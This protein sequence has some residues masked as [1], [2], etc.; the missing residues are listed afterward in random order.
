RLIASGDQPPELQRLGQSI[1][2]NDDALLS[3]AASA[4]IQVHVLEEDLQQQALNELLAHS[5]PVGY[6]VHVENDK[7]VY[8]VPEGYPK[9]EVSEIPGEVIVFHGQKLNPHDIAVVESIH[10][11]WQQAQG[12]N[13]TSGLTTKI[14]KRKVESYQYVIRSRQMAVL[15]ELVARQNAAVNE[16]Q[17]T[18]AGEDNPEIPSLEMR[19][20]LAIRSL[21]YYESL[22][23]ALAI[24]A[25]DQADEVE[26]TLKPEHIK[27][28]SSFIT[29]TWLQMQLAKH[30]SFKP[31]LRNLLNKQHFVQNMLD[32]TL[33][34][35][36]KLM[37]DFIYND[38][39]FAD[40]IRRDLAR[41]LIEVDNK[42]EELQLKEAKLVQF[43]NQLQ[44]ATERADA[45]DKEK[46][47][48]QYRYQDAKFAY[49]TL[50]R[51]M[52]ELE[53]Q[54]QKL[55]QEVKQI[56]KLEQQL[57]DA[58]LEARKTYNSELA[59]MLGIDDWDDTQPPEG[60]ARRLLEKINDM[61][62]K[63]I[64]TYTA[65][66]TS[67]EEAL[68]AKPAAFEGI[69]GTTPINE[70][71]LSYSANG[72]VPNIDK[73]LDATGRSSK[74]AAKAKPAAIEGR[75]GITPV[76]ENDLIYNV[77]G[78]MLI[79]DETLLEGANPEQILA[80][81][82][83]GCGLVP[84][85]KAD[86]KARVRAI[87]EHI[88]HVNHPSYLRQQDEQA[89]QQTVQQQS[90][91]RTEAEKAAATKARLALIASHLNMPDFDDNT[92]IDT[93]HKLL[94]EKIKS[95]NALT[96]K[97]TKLSDDQQSEIKTLREENT[98]QEEDIARLRPAEQ[99][100]AIK[101]KLKKPADLEAELESL[102]TP[103]HIVKPEVL[104]KLGAVEKALKM[105]DF[106]AEDD[107]Y[108]RRNAISE[109]LQT[110]ITK[111][112][113]RAEEDAL[114]VLK[115][116]EEIF[117][118]KVNEG[119]DNR[120]RLHRIRA[121]LDGDDVT[122]KKLDDIENALSK[123]KF[124]SNYE[125]TGTKPGKLHELLTFFVEDAD[126]R[127]LAQQTSMLKTAEDELGIATSKNLAAIERGKDSVAKLAEK[128]QVD[129]I[130]DAS[131]EE[132]KGSLINRIQTLKPLVGSLSVD[133]EG[134]KRY[135]NNHIAR[136]L[137][138]E[139]YR[140]D[141][142]IDDQVNRILEKL[143]ELE[144][145]A[146]T[147][148]Q[149]DTHE[150]IE[151]IDA[152]L[153]RQI[154]R[155][156]PKPRYTLDREVTRARR[157]VA[158]AESELKATYRKLENVR[159]KRQISAGPA[160][161]NPIT[162]EDKTTPDQVMK[163]L[164]ANL[165]LTPVDKQTTEERVNDIRDLLHGEDSEKQYEIAQQLK[166]TTS[167]LKISVDGDPDRL[168]EEDYFN[169]IVTHADTY[170][171]DEVDYPA[172]ELPETR[173]K[174]AQVT[175]FLH[176][177]A[178]RVMEMTHAQDEEKQAQEELNTINQAIDHSKDSDP[179]AKTKLEDER[180][181]Q[182]L[183][184]KQKRAVISEA[185]EDLEAHVATL[186]DLEDNVGLKPDPTAHYTDR[187]DALRNKQLELGGDDG[188]GG[189]I[190]QLTGEQDTLNRE[191]EVRKSEIDKLKKVLHAAEEAAENEGG[192]FQY[193]PGQARIL[194]DLHAYMQ[195]H[196]LKKQALEAVIGLSESAELN[197]KS[198]PNLQTFDLDD[199]FAPIRLQ[200]LAGDNLPFN[201]ASR[202]V[203]VFKDLKATFTFELAEDQSL[204][205]LEE[206]QMLAS[207]ARIYM[208][209]GAQQFDDEIHGIGE[210][211]IHFIEHEPEGLKSFSEYF[212]THSASGHRIITLLREGLI[213]K[214]ELEHYM[215]A[216]RG[217]DGYQLVDE[218]EHFI[219][220]KHGVRVPEF[221]KV[222]QMLS[223]KGAEEFMQSAFTPVTVTTNGPAGMKESFAGMKEYAASVIANYVLDDI[224]F[225]NGR[226]TAAFLTNVQDT[227]TP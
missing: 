178:L 112:R 193:T 44:Q 218:F 209:T 65:P 158:D 2:V 226:R 211:A 166:A 155:L 84:V 200:A 53:S 28:A 33:A 173:R 15:E 88:E 100:Y 105:D 57:H 109:A 19:D 20:R 215:K 175:K 123:E 71:D 136:V 26:F 204:N 203:A 31:V 189:K 72:P 184:L 55:D 115:T 186:R 42:L 29:H 163:K 152:E 85:D 25:S 41:Q 134:V 180:D 114:K 169:A 162:D 208:N 192:P 214:V 156:G 194:A 4:Y 81:I 153:D 118:I 219:G 126:E 43:K 83:R 125:T 98:R 128:L 220:Y 216:V 181:V 210:A 103:R 5:K 212:A 146:N 165:G 51:N 95:L 54:K 56:P 167:E 60:Q 195:S 6:V 23:Q 92:D 107:V 116:A 171:Q 177:H 62:S 225:E 132:Q 207:R 198:I 143:A 96:Q 73:T 8:P 63:V 99:M 131:L 160:D 58:R 196:S 101:F 3:A 190:L 89:N 59:A 135:K 124:T 217:V 179:K 176:E 202:I 161:V 7:R 70:E 38:E 1:F 39:D 13:P 86:L 74:E 147:A 79:Q 47:E 108:Y 14:R 66:E 150:R 97:L 78:P 122:E 30:F 137:N 188:S 191:I 75:S 187:V 69:S 37:N 213:S 94:V 168:T 151:A 32:D 221:R 35:I 129:L 154:A 91:T 117:E 140:D 141:A 49:E 11:L 227:L 27:I 185:Q 9:L 110:S 201:Q 21:A 22:H 17:E 45:S 127:V 199:E 34:S 48:T 144:A 111:F 18:L 145:V 82:E 222:V 24:A 119:D 93:Q 139:D 50:R 130:K 197:G 113:Q 164:Q 12:D 174:Y 148:G 149:P 68:Q 46:Q 64:A 16:G 52:E 77:L 121:I 170:G 120:E 61:R 142:P 183:V 205:P 36:S 224:A 159:R 157:A 106:G 182:A 10:N 172:G 138:I 133:E 76:N 80:P 40:K 102:R 87:K 223:D 206:V 67:D 90:T 104:W